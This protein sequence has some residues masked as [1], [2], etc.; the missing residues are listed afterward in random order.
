M[1]QNGM[2]PGLTLLGAI[3]IAVSL[4]DQFRTL[5]HPEAQGTISDWI[6]RGNW[7]L[8][9]IF[10]GKK[11]LMAAGPFSMLSVIVS[12]AALIVIGFALLYYP[13]LS[14][15]TTQIPVP[16]NGNFT[17]A[18]DVSLGSLITLAGNLTPTVIW[19]HLLM[20]AEAVIGFGLL[21]ASVS[22][23]ISIFPVIEARR[24]LAQ[25]AIWLRECER[26]MGVDTSA[27]PEPEVQLLLWS[28]ATQLSSLR[29][30]IV[31]FPI[32][33]YFRVGEHAPALEVILPFVSDLAER[34][35]QRNRSAG[36]KMAGRTLRFAVE[37]YL[38]IINLFFLHEKT[39]DERK[40]I[41]RYAQEYRR[42]PLT[43]SRTP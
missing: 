17:E 10:P 36:T 33:N 13:R 27:L 9:K 12:W 34:A 22:W 20:S 5:F 42:E 29:N 2:S 38:H 18:L 30:R 23:F 35:S 4:E 40:L 14:Q 8:F 43:S 21:T 25:Q 39:E 31:Q 37:S 19:I 24:T 32:T 6:I 41:F 16:V 1:L 15:F 26:Q 28:L 7:K 11:L 3:L